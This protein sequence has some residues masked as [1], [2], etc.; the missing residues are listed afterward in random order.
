M[1]GQIVIKNSMTMF[2]DL[3]STT[4]SG[5]FPNYLDK[6]QNIDMDWEMSLEKQISLPLLNSPELLHLIYDDDVRFPVF[7]PLASMFLLPDQTPYKVAKASS[8]SFWLDLFLQ[9]LTDYFI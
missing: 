3:K 6:P 5:C 7:T 8:T 9:A 1:G 2:D 4:T